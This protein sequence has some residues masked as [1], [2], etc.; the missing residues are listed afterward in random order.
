[1]PINPI[2]KILGKIEGIKVSNE[3]F[4]SDTFFNS[5]PSISTSNSLTFLTDLY[6]TLFGGQKTKSD[7]VKF[8]T[9]EMKSL[10]EDLLLYFKKNIVE[11]YFCSIDVTIPDNFFE[12]TAFPIKSIDFFG[13]LKVDPDSELG[14]HYYQNY[15]INLDKL[16][17]TAINNENVE[18]NWNSIL[19]IKYVDHQIYV[20]LD[21][22][23]KGKT[24]YNF[25]TLFLGKIQLFDNITIISDVVDAV[26]GAV[27]SLNTKLSRK[28]LENKIKF[29]IM[30]DRISENVET[31]D[32][33]YSFDNEEINEKVKNRQSGYYQY[34]DCELSYVKYDYSLLQ[35][36]LDDL[37]NGSQYNEEIYN[38]NFDFMINQ[39]SP[40]ISPSDKKSYNDNI[41]LTFF[42]QISKSIAFSLFSPKK[43]L[44]IRL[45][46]KMVAKADLDVNFVGFFKQH[47]NFILDI[48]KKHILSAVLKYL[49]VIIRKQLSKLL[50]ENFIKQQQEQLRLYT[51]QIRSLINI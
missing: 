51:E 23:L 43:V 18:Y 19:I 46:A 8:F 49:L 31:D 2:Q 42:R 47:K 39:T 35:G 44:F 36:F 48:I 13:I 38:T 6:K 21:P 3:A 30:F 7:F 17:Y 26:Y 37:S 10:G 33:F 12:Y 1:M 20:K 15:E 22:S 25:V 41:F 50:A 4:S 5:F 34:V 14:K 24:I 16:L 29:E 11:Y 32:S 9:T 45:F 27:T 28:D 40:T